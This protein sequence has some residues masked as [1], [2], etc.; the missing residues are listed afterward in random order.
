MASSALCRG[1]VG[2]AFVPLQLSGT[3]ELQQLTQEAARLQGVSLSAFLRRALIAYVH[4]AEGVP[5]EL[6][7]AI[8]ESA[9]R[10]AS[11]GIAQGKP[12]IRSTATTGEG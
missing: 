8:E 6:A 7:Q 1:A 2:S 4:V 3:R 9:L 5:P 12:A 10:R 11:Q